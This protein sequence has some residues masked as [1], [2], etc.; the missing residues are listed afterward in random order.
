MSYKVPYNT[1]PDLGALQSGDYVPMLRPPFDEG[2]AFVSDFKAAISPLKWYAVQMTQAGGGAP[3]VGTTYLNEIGAISWAYVTTG[4]YTGTLTGAF[5]TPFPKQTNV[6]GLI[7]FGKTYFYAVERVDADNIT[8]Y[9]YREDWTL[10]DNLLL[11]NDINFYCY[12]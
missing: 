9:T 4:T 10:Q 7:E 2:K 12:V 5:T 6:F 3:T 11:N 1:L 8:L